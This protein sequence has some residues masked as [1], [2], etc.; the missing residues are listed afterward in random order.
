VLRLLVVVTADVSSD[1]VVGSTLLVI[2]SNSDRGITADVGIVF[3]SDSMEHQAVV[4]NRTVPANEI[5][6]DIYRFV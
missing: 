3:G 1:P 4:R 6:A 5:L 2:S